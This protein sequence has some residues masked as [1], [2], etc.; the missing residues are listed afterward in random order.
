MCEE[1]KKELYEYEAEY[2]VS[3]KSEALMRMIHT[4]GVFFS[5]YFITT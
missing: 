2:I 5:P 3:E 1:K 4:I